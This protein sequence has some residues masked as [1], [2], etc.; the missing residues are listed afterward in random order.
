MEGLNANIEV[1]ETP[2]MEFACITQIGIQGQSN[3]FERLMKWAAP[4]GLMNSDDFKMA[5]IYYDSFKVTP[6][7]KLRMSACILLNEPVEVSG[8]VGLTT[9]EK[10]KCIIGSYEIGI[11]EFEKAWTGLFIWMSEN[12]YQKSDQN[13]FEIYHNDFNT[14]PKKKCIVDLYIPFK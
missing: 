6:T 10:G 4:K 8:E 5:T 2:K 9:I 13:P 12:G 11:H 3:A 1:K 7:D 14:H